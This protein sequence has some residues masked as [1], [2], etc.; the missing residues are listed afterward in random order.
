MLFPVVARLSRSATLPFHTSRSLMRE[1][2]TCSRERVA[3]SQTSALPAKSL[4][5]F[6]VMLAFRMSN[7]S[8]IQEVLAFLF[9]EKHTSVLSD[10]NDRILLPLILVARFGLYVKRTD[11]NAEGPTGICTCRYGHLVKGN[12]RSDR[13]ACHAESLYW[14]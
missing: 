11:N 9:L 1:V 2:V 6:H 5:A 12:K 14:L 7:A 10:V 3:V 4:C 13:G 8:V